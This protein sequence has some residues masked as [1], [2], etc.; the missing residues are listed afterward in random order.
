MSYIATGML[1]IMMILTVG[2]VTGR[3][4]SKWVSWA[5]PIKGTTELTEL[6]MILVIFPTLAWCALQN[7]HVKVDLVLDHFPKKVQLIVSII[8]LLLTLVTYGIITWRNALESTAVYT[9]NT[10]INIPDSPF[11][12]VLTAGLAVF[13][14]VALTLLIKNIKEAG[15]K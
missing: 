10:L 4:L 7:K 15:K 11:Y 12:W 14:V 5:S 9:T 8:T 2:D 13:C 6:L 3:Y 1:C